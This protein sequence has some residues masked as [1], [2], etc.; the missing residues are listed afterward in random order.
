MLTHNLRTHVKSDVKTNFKTL[1]VQG[2]FK[3]TLS[4]TFLKNQIEELFYLFETSLRT[5][6]KPKN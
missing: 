4:R 1:V 3:H 5:I 2:H 6:C